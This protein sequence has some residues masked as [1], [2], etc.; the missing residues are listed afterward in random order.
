MNLREFEANLRA[1][2][3]EPLSDLGQIIARKEFSLQDLLQRVK[4]NLEAGFGLQDSISEACDAYGYDYD[5]L[6]S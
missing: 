6:I 5:K 2:A 4:E 3:G 1:A